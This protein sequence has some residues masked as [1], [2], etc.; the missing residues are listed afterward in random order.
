MLTYDNCGESKKGSRTISVFV[1]V[2]WPTASKAVV[3]T[4]FLIVKMILP[5]MF[6]EEKEKDKEILQGDFMKE[7]ET[8]E[9]EHVVLKTVTSVTKDKQ[10]IIVGNAHLLNKNQKQTL[11]LKQ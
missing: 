3:V 6:E 9:N 2:Q 1:M 5:K 11:T 4:V 8:T 10:K 7:S